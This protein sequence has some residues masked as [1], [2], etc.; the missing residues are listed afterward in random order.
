MINYIWY[1]LKALQKVVKIGFSYNHDLPVF[2]TSLMQDGYFYFL[3]NNCW[4]YYKY[5][6]RSLKFPWHL[7]YLIFIRQFYVC[8]FFLLFFVV[9]ICWVTKMYCQEISI[10]I[11]PPPAT[12]HILVTLGKCRPCFNY[13][14]KLKIM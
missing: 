2:F 8:L 11:P 13:I 4:C 7:S 9:F 14:L 5:Y 10:P 1:L 12:K 3:S 6:L